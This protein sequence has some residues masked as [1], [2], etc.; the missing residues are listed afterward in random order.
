MNQLQKHIADSLEKVDKLWYGA[1]PEST[2]QLMHQSL[3]Q[4]LE[5]ARGEVRKIIGYHYDGDYLDKD[6][7]GQYLDL[8]DVL[9]TL[10]ITKK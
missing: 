5:I 4:L 2:K 6:S 8:D 3:L 10:T 9:D 1:S 7:D